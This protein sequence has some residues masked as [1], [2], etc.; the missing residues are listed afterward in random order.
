LPPPT[1][2]CTCTGPYS[3]FSAAPVY[4]PFFAPEAAAEDEEADGPADGLDEALVDGDEVVVGAAEPAEAVGD[5]AA[6]SPL[7]ALPPRAVAPAVPDM[8]R[9]LKESSR[10]RPTAVS[11]SASMTL[12]MTLLVYRSKDST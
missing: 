1:V 8:A 2:A 10:P 12:R 11:N 5:W 7:S 3:V 4:E 6:F 9:D